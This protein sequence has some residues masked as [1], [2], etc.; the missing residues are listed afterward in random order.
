MFR[1]IVLKAVFGCILLSFVTVPAICHQ[2]R[3]V[4]TAAKHT[5]KT[6]RSKFH[7]DFTRYMN[8]YVKENIDVLQKIKQRNEASFKLMDAMFKK[9]QL[10]SDLKY[11]AVV[12]SELKY[13][14]VSKVGAVGYCL[15]GTLG[16]LA[17]TRL[18]VQAAVG[19]YGGRIINYVHEQPRC[20][21]ML[22]FGTQDQHIRKADVDKIETARP[23]IEVFWYDAGHGFNCD[24]RASFN[25]GAA[26][27]ARERSLAFLRQNLI[28]R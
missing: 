1:S 23:E 22:H 24:A 11:L 4:A 20:P 28:K 14:A 21:V 15:G 16:W 19:Y 5:A 18:P 10:P 3:V 9:Y 12:E 26:A 27:L 25:P 13:N 8:S 7:Q 6:A 2:Q 17:A